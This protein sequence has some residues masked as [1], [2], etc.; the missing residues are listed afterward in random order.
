MLAKIHFIK[1]TII[2]IRCSIDFHGLQENR[3]NTRN[4]FDILDI[5]MGFCVLFCAFFFPSIRFYCCIIVQ[6]KKGK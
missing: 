1:F 3:R 4:E 5:G 2:F 6:T